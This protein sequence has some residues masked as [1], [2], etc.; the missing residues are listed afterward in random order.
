MIQSKILLRLELYSSAKF[1][2]KVVHKYIPFQGK[3]KLFA[4]L[5]FV[6]FNSLGI[7]VV[8]ATC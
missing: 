4:Y 5:S 1:L 7:I 2:V 3:R 8:Y 6:F